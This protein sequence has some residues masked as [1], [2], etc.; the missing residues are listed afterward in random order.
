VDVYLVPAGRDHHVLYCEPAGEPPAPPAHGTRGIWRRLYDGFNRVLAAIE[1]EHEGAP[2][3]AD[4]TA[5]ASGVWS[6]LR[7]RVL[8]WLAGRVAEQR[9]LWRLQGR[10]DVRAFHPD[11]LEPTRALAFVHDSLRKDASRHRRWLGLDGVLLV[12]SLLLTPVPGPNLLGYYFAFRVVGHVLSIRGARQGLGRVRWDL[13]SSRP[14]GELTGIERLPVAERTDVVRRVA[15]ELGLTRLPRF[16]ERT[17][18]DR[19]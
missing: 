1:H 8:G 18:A 12:F 13:Q 6:R 9:V 17:L 2:G 4:G 16:F 14:L 7:S 11:D 3:D 19:E 10:T 15:G 5:A